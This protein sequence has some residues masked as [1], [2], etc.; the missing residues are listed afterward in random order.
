MKIREL[1]LKGY[2]NE[3][4]SIEDGEE[5]EQTLRILLKEHGH[6][7]VLTKF[8]KVYYLSFQDALGCSIGEDE[9]TECP[10]SV[11]ELPSVFEWVD[12]DEVDKI[13]FTKSSD[14]ELTEELL[15]L[16]VKEAFDKY[17]SLFWDNCDEHLAPETWKQLVEIKTIEKP[18]KLK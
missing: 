10:Y 6:Y 15:N 13:I 11:D 5:W 3:I 12:Y 16:D 4:L 7:E 17:N 14:L 18:G 9:A 8:P 1:K 2:C